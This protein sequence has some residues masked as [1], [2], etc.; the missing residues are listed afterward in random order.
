MCIQELDDPQRHPVKET[1]YIYI[2]YILFIYIYISLYI[3]LIFVWCAH[4]LVGVRIKIGSHTDQTSMGDVRRRMNDRII[5][6]R[7]D[8]TSPSPAVLFLG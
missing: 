3:S 8:V 4:F 1:T 6:Q 2:I 5:G 7:G